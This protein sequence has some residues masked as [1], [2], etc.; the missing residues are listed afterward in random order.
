MARGKFRGAIVNGKE[1]ARRN[2]MGVLV[3]K[4]GYSRSVFHQEVEGKM[5]VNE[6]VVLSGGMPRFEGQEKICLRPCEE[7]NRNNLWFATYIFGVPKEAGSRNDMYGELSDDGWSVG[8]VVGQECRSVRELMRCIAYGE[9]FLGLYAQFAAA[10]G[11]SVE[12]FMT[13]VRAERVFRQAELLKLVAEIDDPPLS[14]GIRGEAVKRL[15]GALLKRMHFNKLPS[16]G[17][18]L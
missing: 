14:G 10:P 15:E 17:V 13:N 4:L 18:E 5:R 3:G 8:Q 1:T 16:I 9:A 11:G 12:K 2:Q 7:R 6:E